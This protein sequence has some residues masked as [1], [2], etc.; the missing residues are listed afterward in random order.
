[1]IVVMK[2]GSTPEQIEA[3]KQRI[4]SHE[5]LQGHLSGGVERTVIGVVGQIFPELKDELERLEGVAEV[6]RISKPYKLSTREFRPHDTMVKV[7]DA[8]IGGAEPVM[9]AGPCAVE[10]EDLLMACAEQVKS[11]GA[12]ILRGGAFKPRTSPYS[13]R[14][15]GVQGLKLLAKAREKYGLPVVTEVMSTED[16]GMVASYADM[17][18]IGTR[19]A[20]NFNLLEAVGKTRKP[21]LL[22][23]GFSSSY[24]EWLLAA[25]YVLSG[26]N[27]QV[28]LCERG[29]RTFEPFTRFTVDISAVPVIKKLSHLPV[30]VDPSHSTG[31]WELVTPI[32]LAAIAAGAHGIIVD[33]HPNP[34]VAKC[35]GAQALTFDKFHDMS[36]KIKAVSMALKPAKV[37]QPA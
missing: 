32:S 22:K 37:K 16:V 1:V 9:M 10:S 35:D 28:V 29:I 5:G 25:E 19:N 31:S 7:G 30:I 27:N 3:V 2:R 26:G 23:R 17:L 20:Q 11:E 18:Q 21:V 24:E 14:G 36:A 15:M 13:F 33:V 12:K 4:E 8:L 6:V 34:T